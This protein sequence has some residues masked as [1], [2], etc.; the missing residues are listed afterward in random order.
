MMTPNDYSGLF[1]EDTHNF[2]AS[3]VREIFRRFPVPPR[4]SF[5]GGYPSKDTFPT[6]WLR[7][8]NGRILSRWGETCLQYGGTQGVDALRECL[9]K[10]YSVPTGNVQIT[11]SS[12]QGIDICARILV[13]PGDIV[14]TQ[15]PTYLGAIQS[16]KSYRAR[17]VG[18]KSTAL[19]R[20]RI[21]QLRAEGGTVKFIYLIPDFCNPSSLT[22]TLEERHEII[23]I[24][25]AAGIPIVED[26]PYREVR[27]SGEQLP[28]IY[29]LAPD[30]TI[31][32][33]SFS[34]VF[35]PGLRLGWMFAPSDI[36]RQIYLCK[37]A[38]DLCPPVLGQYMALDFL[39]SGM[40][41]VNL[42]STLT[43]YKRKR[44]RMLSALEKHMPEGVTWTHPDGGLFIFVTLPEE[45]NTVD[46]YETALTNGV[47]YVSG[48]FFH[49][50]KGEGLNTMRLNFSFC[51]EE[52]IEDGIALLSNLICKKLQQPHTSSR[53]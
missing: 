43:L 17:I 47:S 44:D 13:N 50:R 34:K 36:L 26:S 22:M 2:M 1:S 29:S 18:V 33:G 5:A 24:A 6:Q 8:C 51:P 10:R 4:Y 7:D 31:H 12:Q 16:F 28:S 19:F 15:E 45:F 23:E 9:G 52:D 40:L 11:T 30:C 41:D 46:F 25:R 39:E 14:L 3:P 32:L 48:S 37:Q 20:E 42:R 21:S 35:A 53:P 27:F 38:L 49:T